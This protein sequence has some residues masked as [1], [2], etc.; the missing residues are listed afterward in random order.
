MPP[1]YASKSRLTAITHSIHNS[2]DDFE[3]AF[4]VGDELV[5]IERSTPTWW[6]GCHRGNGIKGVF[7]R[8]LV[9]PRFNEEELALDSDWTVDEEANAR[10]VEAQTARRSEML[11]RPAGRHVSDESSTPRSR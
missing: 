11:G 10:P 7:P 8:H 5:D 9:S 1:F 4:V 3:L 2:S 6:F